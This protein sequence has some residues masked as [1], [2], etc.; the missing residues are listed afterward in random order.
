MPT[1]PLVCVPTAAG[2]GS[3]VTHG[4]VVTDPATHE[5]MVF[6]GLACPGRRSS[7]RR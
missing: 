3:E 1:L 4:I 5:K 2:T 7:I 6:M